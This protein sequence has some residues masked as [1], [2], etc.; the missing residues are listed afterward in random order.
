MNEQRVLVVTGASAGIGA[1]LALRASRAGYAVLAVARREE[2]LN[3][4]AERIRGEG[5]TIV[6]LVGDVRH[7]A[8]SKRIAAAALEHFGRID[9][10]VAN[11]GVPGRG[12]LAL[13]S[14][15]ELL[16][17]LETHVLA[18]LTLIRQSLPLLVAARAAAFVVGSGVARIPIGGMG[19]YPP[20]K[21][22]LRSAARILR[23]ELRPLGVGLTYVD[24]GLVDTE[25]MHRKSMPGAPRSL[26]I[27]PHTVARCI[28]TAV[29]R[30]PAE[31]NAAPWQTAIVA[32]GERLPRLTDFILERASSLTGIGEQR[33]ALTAVPDLVMTPITP[34]VSI[35]IDPPPTQSTEPVVTPEPEPP[36]ATPPPTP[37]ASPTPP[38]VPPPE[39][40][41][42]PAPRATR[43]RTKT[44]PVTPPLESTAPFDQ[45]V[46]SFASRM[47][48]LNLAPEMLRA[49]WTAGST[50]AEEEFALDWVGMPNKNERRLIGDICA[51][52]AELGLLTPIG[53][54]LWSVVDA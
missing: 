47:R 11:A 16:E 40:P 12:P 10:L 28:L 52:A 8:T 26:M 35:P 48:R 36:I 31:I 45:L 15:E 37:E 3:A 7:T 51:A 20:S 1:A 29:D 34:T 30:R 44:E 4:L 41:S 18:P 53:E 6:T 54:G 17:Q 50:F 14:D 43:S 22:T 9:V 24:P 23:R 39:Q 13:Q 27:S 38:P 49:R 21:A 5:G 46:D 33:I 32:L 19:L 25:F 2:Q 42:S